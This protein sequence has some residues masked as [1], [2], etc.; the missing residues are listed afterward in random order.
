MLLLWEGDNI[1]N[2]TVENQ[3]MIE[4]VSGGFQLI[5]VSSEDSSSLSYS[6][7]GLPQGI[8]LSTTGFLSGQL[9]SISSQYIPVSG[10]TF[11]GNITV[12]DT[13]ITPSDLVPS[14]VSYPYSIIVNN[15]PVAP[16]W[17][18][19][20]DIGTYEEFQAM[21]FAFV[22]TDAD[23]YPVT[24]S[25]SG[26]PPYGISLD[27]SSGIISGTPQ[28]WIGVQR[29]LGTVTYNF[30]ITATVNTTDVPARNPVF[31]VPQNFTM[32]V[33]TFNEPPVWQT[34]SGSLGSD[35]CTNQESIQ[36]SAY[37]PEGQN[38]TY[39][40]QSGSLPS[41]L[42]LSPSGLISGI[43]SSVTTETSSTFTIAASDGV[44]ETPRDF[45]Y[46]VE[47]VPDSGPVWNTPPGNIGSGYPGA[48]FSFQLSANE[49]VNAPAPLVYANGQGT[50][51]P[52]TVSVN[53]STG[54][55]SGSLPLTAGTYNFTLSIFD[56]AYTV[57][58]SFSITVLPASTASFTFTNS[59]SPNSFT[60]PPG[61]YEITLDWLIG[62]GG[63]GGS[64]EEYGNGGGGGGG[65]SGGYYQ[66]VVVPCSPGDVFSFAIGHGGTA[67]VSIKNAA[68]TLVSGGNGGS[69]ICYQNGN[70]IYIASGG[71]G[72]Q[73]ATNYNSGYIAAYG[74][75]GG[76]PNGIA[77]ENGV[78]GTHDTANCDG[79]SGAAT[80]YP[81]SV[82]GTAGLSYVPANTGGNG[83]GPG[84]GGGGG[85]AVDRNAAG[86]GSGG[87]GADGIAVCHY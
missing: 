5:G 50:T 11:S 41:G 74:G 15:V 28:N 3:A 18:T 29:Q 10:S 2:A 43:L 34:P 36:L 58:R 75:A 62:A 69:T 71:T 86:E 54:L 77:G 42:N 59:T 14:T 33:V 31:N 35:I 56:G 70:V 83:T 24:Y 55:L 80:P 64:G 9:P 8:S 82:G 17:V 7:T 4:A 85:G 63:G 21:S 48:A 52:G 78:T 19:T 6:A 23:G 51:P 66:G 61:V 87:S 46:V 22:A 16:I 25:I 1:T 49:T 81:G 72:G 38:I 79:G 84:A 12:T 20:G 73:G 40:I 26:S 39:S 76:S 27:S 37:D 53:S 44:N 13:S 45:S 65:G 30:T 60:V 47:P 68:V 57:Y 67:G 32:E